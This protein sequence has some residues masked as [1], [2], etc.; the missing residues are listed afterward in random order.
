MKKL[1]I[2]LLIVCLF[3]GVVGAKEIHISNGV[4]LE[5]A[6]GNYTP[7]SKLVI[8]DLDNNPPEIDPTQGPTTMMT[9]M[10]TTYETTFP[11]TEPTQE[12]PIE[13]YS[14]TPIND[15]ILYIANPH[16]KA[17]Y[18]AKYISLYSQDIIG[19]NKIHIGKDKVDITIYSAEY[20]ASSGALKLNLTAKVNNV[21][22]EIHNPYRVY[23]PIVDVQTTEAYFNENNE[24]IAGETVE[25]PSSATLISIA[26]QVINFP[27]GS[28]TFDGVDPT[29]TSY[30]YLYYTLRTVATGTTFNDIVTGAGTSA[31]SGYYEVGLNAYDETSFRTN[32]R[33]IFWV[34]TS[35]SGITS[36]SSATLT[37]IGRGKGDDFGTN[38]SVVITPC[39]PA[40]YN[41]TSASD[42]S[43]YSNTFIASNKSYASWP[44][45]DPTN[46]NFTLN[47]AG[48]S[49]I[50]K[51]GYSSYM[52]RDSY[53]VDQSYGG[54]VPWRHS[55]YSQWFTNYTGAGLPSATIVYT[56]VTP[57]VASFDPSGTTSGS[58]PLS[59][60]FT[61]TSTNTPTSWSWAFNNVTGNNTWIQFNT[62]QNPSQ[63]FGI[64]NF[65]INLSASNAAGTNISTQVSWV[66]VSAPPA[67]S[68]FTITNPVELSGI[69]VA[70]TPLGSDGSSYNW[71]WGD[72]TWTN[73]T[74]NTATSHVYSTTNI[75]SPSLYVYKPYASV[76][77]TTKSEAVGIDSWKI[78]PSTD[79]YVSRT[80]TGSF[81][82]IRTGAGS[83]SDSSSTTAYARLSSA[84][85]TNNYNR[86][87]RRIEIYDAR[88]VIPGSFT[89][90]NAS[91]NFYGNAHSSTFSTN[92][93]YVATSVTTL[94][95]LDSITSSDYN[96]YG[97]DSYGS[98]AY[99]DYT[100]AGYNRM[101]LNATGI[102]AIDRTTYKTPFMLRTSWDVSGT[103]PT[104]S[105]SKTGYFQP[106]T[107][108]QSGTTQDPFLLVNFSA[109][110]VYWSANTTVG[111]IGAS[112]ISFTDDSPSDGGTYNWS[113]GDGT[114]S[115]SRNVTHTYTTIGL[116]TV[117]F[118]SPYPGSV[119]LE[120]TDYINISEP[121][122]TCSPVAGAIPLSVTCTDTSSVLTGDDWWN[123][124][125]GYSVYDGGVVSHT[126]TVAGSYDVQL[127]TPSATG[128][129]TT[130]TGYVNPGTITP[131]AGFTSNVTSVAAGGYVQFTDTSANTPTSW[132]WD[133]NGG[134]ASDSTSQNPVWQFNTVGNYS[135]NLTV[136]N[137]VGSDSEVKTNYIRVYP[138]G[139]YAGM[140]PI[141]A[142]DFTVAPYQYTNVNNALDFT[143]T[144]TSGT[145]Q[146]YKWDFN[147]GTTT[148]NA[149][150]TPSYTYTTVGNKTVNFT[151][152]NA[153]SSYSVIKPDYIQVFGAGVPYANFYGQPT[154][155]TPG[156]LITFVDTGLHGTS[157][158]LVCN[159]SFGDS[160]YTTTPYSAICG[161][162][163]HVYAYAGV[164]DVNFSITNANGSSYMFKPQYITVATSQTLTWWSPHQVVL[165][166]VD[167]N[168]VP[169]TNVSLSAN[170]DESTLP[171][172]LAGAKTS[173]VYNYG[174]SSVAA[175]TMIDSTIHLNG[176]TGTDGHI[177]FT[178]LGSLQYTIVVTDANGNSYTTK[179]YPLD[180][181]YQIWTG[182]AT[183]KLPTQ[184]N[185]TYSEIAN[186]TLTFSE[187]NMS[188]MTMGLDYL[189]ISG[190]TDAIQFYVRLVDNNTVMFSRNYSVSGAQ[191]ILVNYTVPNVRTQQWKWWYDA[192]RSA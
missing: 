169:L 96:K 185:N 86:L 134:T 191:H 180:D 159:W 32:Y 184:I 92:P 171:G 70:F 94:A 40:S 60:S 132:I 47:A 15:A 68:D 76:N 157:S 161:D 5:H 125:D 181:H 26:Q 34:N 108:E 35:L 173:L 177:T 87:D 133:F 167:A 18:K 11:T 65:S 57:P 172:G 122:F 2:V 24:P 55:Y 71:S 160:I 59:V 91:L 21:E 123:F 120:R 62:I 124:D 138:A 97:S 29:L 73:L 49:S 30:G 183:T 20:D 79:G 33:P 45:S 174:I 52:L 104:W 50:N 121:S 37:I 75:Y 166:V 113:F 129:I 109:S 1:L 39:T 188:Y 83:S 148:D 48:I 61:D 90:S 144:V 145:A 42:Y 28:P 98:I 140:Q 58:S 4:S 147:G 7:E 128:D 162:V 41:T 36:I 170:V 54:I 136:T 78:Y 142:A 81:S 72:G 80:S 19:E 139:W 46:V 164:Y 53:D 114:Y 176:T 16:N 175:D 38:S 56:V 77:I 22:K 105:G 154:T 165:R 135:V 152:Y 9:T 190:K 110:P 13:V 67:I 149:T 14:V 51:S 117:R 186:S 82:T 89:I 127:Q 66:N 100:N 3:V 178:M 151:A 130:Y 6:H 84:A 179:L 192:H 189:D 158:G 88:G 118:T 155:G 101:Y 12:P 69:A 43:S 137:I 111:I 103:G 8:Y 168:G 107:S 112:T 27:D 131:V 85:T 102:A 143:G 23:N 150:S 187:P 156:V 25:E 106:F 44:S 163:N 64:G 126:Y 153:I 74:S 10:E 141:T 116:N 146:W 63:S 115:A 182:S 119:Y 17:E 95:S 93:N 99:A 31:S